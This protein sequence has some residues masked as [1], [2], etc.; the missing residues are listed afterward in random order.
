MPIF[1]AVKG[2]SFLGVVV[3]VITAGITAKEQKR[4]VVDLGV[5]LPGILKKLPPAARGVL[6][7]MLVGGRSD[8]KYW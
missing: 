2:A 3:G 6:E 4:D 8:V 1:S 7:A 5:W